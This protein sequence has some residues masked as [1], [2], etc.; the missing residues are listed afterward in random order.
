M[1]SAFHTGGQVNLDQLSTATREALRGLETGPVFIQGADD[2]PAAVIIPA[3]LFAEFLASRKEALPSDLPTSGL[4][5]VEF[6][7]SDYPG[8][9]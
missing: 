8:E 6:D 3:E 1:F 7:D 4:R 2:K 9:E 5:R